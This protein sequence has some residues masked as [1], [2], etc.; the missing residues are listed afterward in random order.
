MDT[1]QLAK[2]EAWITELESRQK[3]LAAS[4]TGY[5][6]FFVGALVASAGG[7]F[8]NLWIGA[9]TLFTGVMFCA[10]GFYSVMI[11]EGDYV[12]EL[13]ATRRE[14]ARIRASEATPPYR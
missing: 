8:F 7:F 3:I 13:K 6:R 11:R 2:Y 1:E 14:V 4:R 5:L 10:F 9:A 12:R